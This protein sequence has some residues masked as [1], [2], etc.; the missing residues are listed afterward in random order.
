ME[1]REPTSEPEPETATTPPQVTETLAPTGATATV[2]VE[3]ANCRAKPRG[4][5]DR[6]TILYKDQQVEIV[7]KNNDPAN[8]W[9]YIRI[10]DSKNHCWLWGM[11]AKTTGKVKDIPI[12]EP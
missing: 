3:S 11:T 12:V 9:W 7:G 8:P 1:G 6:V 10:P 4:N 5:G 2:T